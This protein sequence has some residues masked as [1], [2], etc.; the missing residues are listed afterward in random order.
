[1]LSISVSIKKDTRE[2][3]RMLKNLKGGADKV[4][5]RALNKTIKQVES[6]AV[7]GIAKN[8]RVTQRAVRTSIKITR[9]RYRQKTAVI[10]VSGKRMPIILLGARQTRRGVTY[11]GQ[12]GRR[13]LI[14]NAFIATINRHNG[15]FKRVGRKKLPIVELRGVS[16][17]YVFLQK[18]I[19]RAMDNEASIRWKKNL[20]HE[21]KW[22][23]R[24]A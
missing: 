8:I 15:V 18:H 9:A 2:V 17:P 4:I 12:G 23:I 11:K 3:E 19:Q 20:A 13:K 14:P 10:T 21:L 7:K 22:F 1:M 16:I 6:A 5:T 24:N